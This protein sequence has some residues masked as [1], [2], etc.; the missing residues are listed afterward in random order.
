MAD[1]E[2]EQSGRQANSSCIGAVTNES[3]KKCEAESEGK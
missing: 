3:G 1:C 2:L